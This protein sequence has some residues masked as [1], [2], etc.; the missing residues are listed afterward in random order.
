MQEK[1]ET[2]SA[3]EGVHQPLAA[4]FLGFVAMRGCSQGE[5]LNY[6]EV[7]Y[8]KEFHWVPRLKP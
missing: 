4:V 7:I 6:N 3:V 8:F 2:D 1:A 5:G